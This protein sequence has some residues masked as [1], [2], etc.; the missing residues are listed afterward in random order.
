MPFSE[1][2]L[3]YSRNRDV[4]F[5]THM[6]KGFWDYFC[7]VLTWGVPLGGV[8]GWFLTLSLGTTSGKG[9]GV[10]CPRIE[11]V[12]WFARQA[13]FLC[14]ISLLYNLW[15]ITS[16]TPPCTQL[17]TK[18]QGILSYS[19]EFCYFWCSHQ[20]DNFHNSDMDLGTFD[21]DP[22]MQ[23]MNWTCGSSLSRPRSPSFE[24]AGL[25]PWL[26]EYKGYRN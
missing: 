18:K 25:P 11:L 2:L 21:H 24:T 8:Q 13:P 17:Q 20:R 1:C 26:T 14:T 5:N 22:P 3:E 4:W 9:P 19:F 6:P 12:R 16:F 10:T 7:S 23:R 15:K